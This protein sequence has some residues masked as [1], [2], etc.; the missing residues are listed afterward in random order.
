MNSFSL[1][2]KHEGKWIEYPEQDGETSLALMEFML[3][4]GVECMALAKTNGHIEIFNI[5][6]MREVL[7]ACV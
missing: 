1:R 5:N 3:H 6:E 7:E 2:V 4:R